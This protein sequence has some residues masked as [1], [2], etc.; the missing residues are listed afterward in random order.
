MIWGGLVVVMSAAAVLSFAALRELAATVGIPA[1]LTPLLPVAVDAG[2]AVSCSTWLSR[3]VPPQ[4]AR[5]ACGMTWG[6]LVLTVAGN[7]A[8]LGMHANAVVPPWWVAVIVGAVPPA[9]VGGTVHLAVLVARGYDDAL[10]DRLT[11]RDRARQ[12]VAAGAGR[13]RLS[14]E[15][16]I[17]D[18]QA[19]VLIREIRDE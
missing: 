8:Q 17:T 15:L 13:P 12:L 14:R 19:R 2:A 16:E 9:V 4:A 18:H 1:P 3:R 5:F 11:L 7:A 10:G 6:L